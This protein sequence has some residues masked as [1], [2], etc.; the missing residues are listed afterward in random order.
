[1]LKI[2]RGISE[3][4]IAILLIAVSLAAIAI[5]S[6]SLNQLQ[7]RTG[8][9]VASPCIDISGISSVSLGN[10]C[11]LNNG[12]IKARVQRNVDNLDIKSIRF[13]FYDNAGSVKWRIY[14]NEKCLDARRAETEY[15][16]YCEI[17][18]KGET[19][20]YIFNVSDINKQNKIVLSLFLL[21]EKGAER[22]CLI[23]QGDVREGC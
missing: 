4:V 12:E 5:F 1:M 19:A 20:E 11:Y 22:E 23:G 15:G 9:E 17:V 2:K 7:K 13:N 18:R 21:D 16:G 3:V 8:S 6:V 10:T 14:G